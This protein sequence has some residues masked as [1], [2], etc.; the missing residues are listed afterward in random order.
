MI[1]SIMICAMIEAAAIAHGVDP[2]FCKA[3]ARIESGT[4][5]QQF[6]VGR[7]GQSKYFGPFGIHQDF[8]RLWSVDDLETN[9]E[10]GVKALRGKDKRAVL[11]RYNPKFNH[12]Y[13]S[14]IMK[15][16]KQYQKERL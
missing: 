10:V 12:K 5:T 7:L 3:V 11:K 8:I 1:T 4:K 13:Y 16:T 15:L 6:R 14:E 2:A 9:I